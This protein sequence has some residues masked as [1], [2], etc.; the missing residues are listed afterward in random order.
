MFAMPLK[1]LK[2]KLRR[3][4]GRGNE[5]ARGDGRGLELGV[6]VWGISLALS[7]LLSQPTTAN[8]SSTGREERRELSAGGLSELCSAEVFMSVCV[9][10]FERKSLC[11]RSLTAQPEGEIREIGG[12]EEGGRGGELGGW[13][14]RLCAELERAHGEWE[15]GVGKGGREGSGRTIK[16]TGLL[17]S[18]RMLHSG[19]LLEIQAIVFCLFI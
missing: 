5:W 18:N 1:T 7:R 13:V 2:L 16:A 17:C 10:L 3:R 4:R 6:S 19:R 12:G 11:V 14:A 15:G 8:R 9:C